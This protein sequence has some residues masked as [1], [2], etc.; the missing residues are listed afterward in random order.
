MPSNSLYI[1]AGVTIG[2]PVHG[3]TSTDM[4]IVDGSGNLDQTTQPDL[5]LYE[6][7]ANKVNTLSG[8]NSTTYPTSGAVASYV[9]GVVSGLNSSRAI[10]CATITI[11]PNS[12]VYNNGASGVGATLTAGANAALVVDGRTVALNERVLVKNQ[13]ASTG[14][15]TNGIFKQTTLGDGSTAWIL[16]RDT[17]Y[18]TAAEINAIGSVP[19][20]YGSINATTSWVLISSITTVGTDALLFQQFTLTPS[21]L[22][23]ITNTLAQFAAT[24]SA[25]LR[26]IISDPT[27]TG[28]LM[29][30]T[31]PHITTSL[32][33]D[34]GANIVVST[35]T[36]T[37]IGTSTSSK[38]GF[39]NATPVIQQT[40]SITTAL[41][42]LGLVSSPTYAG[43]ID[44]HKANDISSGIGNN[45][46]TLDL[47]A[48]YGYTINELK[49]ISQSGICTAKI[50]INGVD[51]TGISSV[52]VSTTIATGTAS[53]ANT[54]VVGD[55]V[56]LV[57]SSTSSLNNM[58]SVTKYTRT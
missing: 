47:Y 42:N 53:A 33:M 17:S 30:G 38:L 40:G 12:P 37:K 31:T 10:E 52:A 16:T 55:K 25:Q 3:G 22:A 54:V 5:I 43:L 13:T 56:T 15:A 29:F 32:A 49:I 11:L 1:S 4:L 7:L 44:S 39:F 45:T 27:G 26:G 35:G 2:N 18:D 23:L 41:S 14:A 9:S 58:Q 8:S 48:E 21:T 28:A 36:G 19:I 51:V 24:T 50:Q 57:L 20:I 46:Y 34:D 6:L